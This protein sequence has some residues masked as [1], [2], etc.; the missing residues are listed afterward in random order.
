MGKTEL[1]REMLKDDR[2]HVFDIDD[3]SLTALH[4]AVKRNHLEIMKILIKKGAI[5][6]CFDM[7]NRTP[8]YLATIQANDQAV[9]MLLDCKAN[10]I[11]NGV[12]CT[13]VIPP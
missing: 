5:V 2:F 13:D 11:F 8:L 3:L 4:W 7:L 6:N 1:V 10:P 9:S 12:N